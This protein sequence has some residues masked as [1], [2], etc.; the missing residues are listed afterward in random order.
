MKIRVFLAIT[1][2]L[3]V[4]AGLAWAGEGTE[5]AFQLRMGGKADEAVKVLENEFSKEPGQAVTFF[6][7]ARLRCYLMDFSACLAAI[8]RAVALDPDNGRYRYF[9]GF[10]SIFAVID[11]AHDQ[12]EGKMK[13]LG[14]RALGELEAAVAADPD[15]HEARYLLV[16]QLT[17]L[18]PELGLDNSGRQAHVEIL[19]EKDPIWGAKARCCLLET[20]GKRELWEGVLADYGEDARACYEAAD[21]FL[22]LN[23]VARAAEC[24]DKALALDR[25][26][27]YLLLRL[28]MAYAMQEDW[29]R[30]TEVG[31]RYLDLDPPLPL[32]AWTTFYLGQIKRRQGDQAGG[33]DLISQAEQLDPHVWKTFSPPPEIL[34]TA[35]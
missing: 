27:N 21:A 26:R 6:E 16:Q 22:D 14:R 24:L 8:D 34:F 15:L 9:S 32:R 7:M 28:G 29:K 30:A 2:G 19:E 23:D 18:A 17:D 4:A 35:P 33:R 1:A 11:A 5:K 25:D 3:A 12:D 31:D 20:K 13:D 10:V